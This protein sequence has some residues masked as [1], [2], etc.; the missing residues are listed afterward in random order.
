MSD[1]FEVKIEVKAAL[2]AMDIPDYKRDA[3]NVNNVKWLLQNLRTRNSGHH[4]Y[5]N[6]MRELIALAKARNMLKRK[7]ESELQ[8]HLDGLHETT[9]FPALDKHVQGGVPRKEI[10]VLGSGTGGRSIYAHQAAITN[11]KHPGHLIVQTRGKNDRS[12]GG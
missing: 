12:S 2:L 3:S 7:E 5:Q 9:G 10:V 4:F 1:A 11:A 6:T 8:A